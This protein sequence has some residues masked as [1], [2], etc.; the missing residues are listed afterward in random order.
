MKKYIIIFLIMTLFLF[1]GI[2]QAEEESFGLFD[3]LE[4]FAGPMYTR[5]NLSDL[6]ND[7]NENLTFVEEAYE[8]MD[9]FLEEAEQDDFQNADYSDYSFDYY[10]NTPSSPVGSPGFFLGLAN[11]TPS[12]YRA[13]INYERFYPSIRG[14]SGF[15]L[16]FEFSEEDLE[17]NPD[18]NQAELSID[19]D[20]RMEIDFTINGGIASFSL[21]IISE[22]DSPVTDILQYFHV[23][24]GAG[25]YWGT[26]EI[27]LSGE[28]KEEITGEDDEGE[29]VRDEYSDSFDGN[30]RI[31]VSSN[32]GLKAGGGFRIS[33]TD[34]V[35]I[36][37]NLNYRYL[38]MEVEL[39]EDDVDEELVGDET[40]DEFLE[41]R[42]EDFGGLDFQIGFSY[43][44]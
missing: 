37:G 6:V 29:E 24:V 16:W 36:F 19:F 30:Y 25:Y 38:K 42:T 35:D 8:D 3:K 23:N 14:S 13:I 22:A 44:F 39:D 21:P 34:D 32:V 10:V 43:G 9:Q 28:F 27:N 7:I 33:A 2:V 4:F 26:G 18:Y 31:D 20:S 5:V 11:E 40:D 17:D 1:S 41:S 12:G 15:D